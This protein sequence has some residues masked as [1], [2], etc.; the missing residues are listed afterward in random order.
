MLVLGAVNCVWTAVR[1]DFSTHLKSRYPT[2]FFTLFRATQI[3][4]VYHCAGWILKTLLWEF[5][6]LQVS[7]NIILVSRYSFVHCLVLTLFF[8]YF[9]F[10]QNLFLV[11]I[12][13]GCLAFFLCLVHCFV[14]DKY[15]ALL[16]RWAALSL[17]KILLAVLVWQLPSMLPLSWVVA[18]AWCLV[19]AAVGLSHVD[20]FSARCASA[21]QR[22]RDSKAAAAAAAQAAAAAFAE[23]QRADKCKADFH[24]AQAKRATGKT[25]KAAKDAAAQVKRDQDAQ[26]ATAHAARQAEAEAERVARAARTESQATVGPEVFRT[27]NEWPAGKRSPA[28]SPTTPAPADTRD[29]APSPS[30]SKPAT[31][32]TSAPSP[33]VSKPATTSTSAPSGS[34]RGG[35]F[36]PLAV[37]KR[38]VRKARVSAQKQYEL[39]ER[40]F[41]INASGMVCREFFFT[42]C[43]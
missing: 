17:A 20:R 24:A 43:F 4:Q 38:L 19:I 6:G 9:F 37:Y 13:G 21:A 27:K 33:S 8:I 14:V 30:V 41:A 32:S 1:L 23:R 31:T 36:R 15:P 28:R 26:R 34:K 22:A 18:L 29:D 40:R 3:C 2:H 7:L 5:F 25:A 11:V 42:C 12:G 10:T 35:K 16:S 39:L